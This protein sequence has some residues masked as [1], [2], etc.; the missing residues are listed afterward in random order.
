MNKLQKTTHAKFVKRIMLS[1]A[2]TVAGLAGQADDEPV[3]YSKYTKPHKWDFSSGLAGWENVSDSGKVG[4]GDSYM[5][6]TLYGSFKFWRWQKSFRVEP[7]AFEVVKDTEGFS[8]LRMQPI[9]PVIPKNPPDVFGSVIGYLVSPFIDLTFNDDDK[10]ELEIRGDR[11]SGAYLLYIGGNQKVWLAPKIT[12]AS[13]G[14]KKWSF[15]LEGTR[16]IITEANKFKQ[17]RKARVLVGVWVDAKE[18]VVGQK[19]SPTEIRNIVTPPLYDA[20]FVPLKPSDKPEI[21]HLGTSK[22]Q[23]E[24]DAGVLESAP[25]PAG[26]WSSEKGESPLLLSVDE[27]MEFYR[28]RARVGGQ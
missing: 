13:D 1:T 9:K 4:Y 5:S 2:L 6:D 3:D 16:T 27:G 10:L 11:R 8:V 26:P 28:L 12:P 18:L 21:T 15:D 23:V 25:T 14:Y 22:I 17:T 19:W 24:W 7:P 20:A